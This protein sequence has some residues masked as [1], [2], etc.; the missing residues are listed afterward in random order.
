MRPGIQDL[1]TCL[2][3]CF[4]QESK[5]QVDG[6][7]KVHSLVGEYK[8]ECQKRIADWQFGPKEFETSEYV[9]TGVYC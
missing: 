8:K 3:C 6:K 9:C 2:C 1:L 7:D 4:L 5:P